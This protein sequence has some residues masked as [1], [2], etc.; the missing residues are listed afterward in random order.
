M[1]KPRGGS[2]SI[3]PVR[4]RVPAPFDPIKACEGY[5][6]GFETAAPAEQTASYLHG[7][8]KGFLDAERPLAGFAAPAEDAEEERFRRGW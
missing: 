8:R 3:L 6:A 4:P 7:W 5:L 2:A 1:S